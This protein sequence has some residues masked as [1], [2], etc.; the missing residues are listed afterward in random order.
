LP[1]EALIVDGIGG[2]VEARLR[3]AETPVEPPVSRPDIEKSVDA[4]EELP[5]Y[6]AL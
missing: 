3:Y 6:N 4:A 5:Q 1:N 2:R